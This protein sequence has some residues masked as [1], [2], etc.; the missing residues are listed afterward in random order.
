MVDIEKII[1]IIICI[2]ET[3]SI[4]KE[5][6]LINC[7]QKLEINVSKEKGKIKCQNEVLVTQNYLKLLL[8]KLKIL[9]NTSEINMFKI[10]EQ[11]ITNKDNFMFDR[12]CYL[13]SN[14]KKIT[15]HGE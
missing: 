13:L 5:C 1:N 3:L 4:K 7:E 12:F 10:I 8:K 15:M 14:F 2:K 9:L 11:E 6:F